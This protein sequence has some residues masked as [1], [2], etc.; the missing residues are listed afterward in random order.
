MEAG[1]PGSWRQTELWIELARREDL[2]SESLRAIV[3][4][5]MPK[6]ER[7]LG[8]GD[9]QPGDFTLHDAA[10]SHRVA[11][12]IA[13]LAT[14]GALGELGSQD[15]TMLLLS[16]YLHDVGMTPPLARIDGHLAFLLSGD[17]S[18]LSAA[19]ADELQAWLDDEWD[20]LTPPLS[21]QAPTVAELRLARQ[22]VAGYVRHRHNDWGPAWVR[23][24]LGSIE[25][26]YAGWLDDLI[27]LCQSHHFDIDQLRSA[28]FTP[29]LVGAPATV[30]HLRYCACLLRVADVLDFD[31][32]RTPPILFAHRDVS[33]T[34]A[35]FW[36]KDQRLAFE[37]DG[38]HVNLHA[39]PTDAMVHNAVEQTLRDVNGELLLSRRLAD[40]TDFRH[41]AGRDSPLPH[42]WTIDTTVRA[43][44]EPKDG[45]YEYI[46][47]TFR[48][49][50][51]RLLS[52]V[53]GVALYG[54]PLAAVREILQNAFDAVREQMA[55]ERLLLPNPAGEDGFE[56]I[57]ALHRVSLTL[58]QVEENEYRLTCRDTG[59]GMSR[60]TIR[61]RFLVGG[62]SA[63]HEIRALERACNEHGFSVGRTARFGIGVLSY[64]ILGPHLSVR[65]R[66]SLEA[67]DPDGTGW[68]FTSNGLE[69][70]GELRPEP[71]A[72]A[73]TEI[74]LVLH[75][76]LLESA[77]SV[78]DGV[79]EVGPSTF[80]QKLRRYLARTICRVPCEF[81]FEAPGLDCP[82]LSNRPGWA[83]RGDE[84]EKL[85]L[86]PTQRDR[87]PLR[88]A[89]DE[90]IPNRRRKALE[91]SDAHA[92]EMESD[93]RKRLRVN[94]HE[95]P[96]PGGLGVARFAIGTF[97]LIWGTS[98]PYL[99]LTQDS[100][101][102]RA[103]RSL[104]G[105]DAGL[106]QGQLT[107]SWNGM[108]VEGE[109][110]DRMIGSDP[111]GN[112][113]SA[114]VEIDWTNDQA[115]R[116]AVHRNT[117]S[118]S[119]RATDAVTWLM[120][121]IDRVR[122]EMVA[123]ESE[124]R[125]AFLNSRIL[126][127]PP[128]PSMPR[129]WPIATGPDEAAL[130]DLRFP[131]IELPPLEDTDRSRLQWRGETICATLP[132][133]TRSGGGFGGTRFW[134]GNEFDPT[135]LAVTSIRGRI[136]PVPIWE[137]LEPRVSG[138]FPL[139]TVEF[140]P[141]WANLVTTKASHE[142]SP[143]HRELWNAS[144]PLL[145]AL[146]REGWDWNERTFKKTNNPLPYRD[147][148]MAT[149]GRAAGWILRSVD[150][151]ET[152]LWEA[153]AAESPGFLTDVWRL[154]DG[155]DGVEEVVSWIEGSE[156]EM[157][158]ALSP[159][160]WE[161]HLARDAEREFNARFPAPADEWWIEGPA[162]EREFRP[163]Y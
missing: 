151:G 92:A 52:L 71:D 85:M 155:L 63:D 130:T 139:C 142:L 51:K 45:A 77:P 108:T 46:D 21:H 134:H 5:A 59:T 143:S 148:L 95:R 152:E 84:V 53:G 72:R 133:V 93:A 141:K 43:V 97:D 157:L 13:E 99:D 32:E 86:A 140:P 106:T 29:R 132:I 61:S 16:A 81:E 74:T 131:A 69:D 147:E 150:H 65:T 36:H 78:V 154:V 102:G 76:D 113:T 60:D 12:R 100:D 37:I 10:H 145:R 120:Q 14:P 20:G 82:P 40:E 39:R 30:L 162:G 114:F 125:L 73:G 49:N 55:R 159:Q 31:P 118:P 153:V 8:G 70:F 129:F 11:E 127:L 124:S 116:L 137:R 26:P 34:S 19:E 4:G 96:L 2:T 27:A 22:I 119:Q 9:T 94:V 160:R 41:L 24:H 122:N 83:D 107:M 1:R 156:D 146:D 15:L 163:G 23:E 98:F 126:D 112:T 88:P 101:A 104:P 128:A 35:I 158:F 6:V 115:G 91:Q 47:G 33:D 67:G 90:L 28:T 42:R 64:F 111:N 57:A 80:A 136:Q 161:G 121:E 149:P 17:S 44:I 66:R 135:A 62:I 144:H 68:N 138:G 75:E 123:R 54:T 18:A 38:N 103:F 7:V 109:G 117:F 110:T 3:I 25:E 87:H 89:D 56:R 50:P 79:L 48:P 105:R 58:A